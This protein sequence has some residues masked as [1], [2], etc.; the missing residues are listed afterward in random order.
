MTAAAGATPGRGKPSH[1]EQCWDIARSIT[2]LE[3][4]IGDMVTSAAYAGDKDTLQRLQRR[5]SGIVRR[6]QER[7]ERERERTQVVEA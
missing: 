4:R 7:A 2:G 3:Q 5:L 1:G 6:E